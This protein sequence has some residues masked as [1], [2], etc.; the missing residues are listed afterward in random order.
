MYIPDNYDLYMSYERRQNRYRE[1]E[2]ED[3]EDVRDY[4]EELNNRFKRSVEDDEREKDEREPDQ[5]S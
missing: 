4:F 1:D 5:K 2:D 3:K